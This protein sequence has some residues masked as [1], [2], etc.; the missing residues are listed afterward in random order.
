MSTSAAFETRTFRGVDGTNFELKSFRS[1]S[2]GEG[3][4]C[5]KLS[6]RGFGFDE[7]RA[8]MRLHLDDL[9][10]LS[11]HAREA[12]IEALGRKSME[13]TP[14]ELQEGDAI[15]GL[16]E[17]ASVKPFSPIGDEVLALVVTLADTTTSITF[18]PN[19]EGKY[20]QL[21]DITRPID[22]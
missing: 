8:A 14:S 2:E 16:G 9:G 20:N 6:R 12:Y 10:V 22:S 21:I 18:S 4:E 13:V 1:T 11:M 7:S 3:M 15:D 19:A 5:A 17:V